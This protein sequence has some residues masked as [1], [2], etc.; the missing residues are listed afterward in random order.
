MI[1]AMFVLGSK[2]L[3]RR[4][5]LKENELANI[6]EETNEKRYV[7]GDIL[8]LYKKIQKDAK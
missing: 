7:T 6:D 2:T 8:D 3:E 1:I 5:F 4:K